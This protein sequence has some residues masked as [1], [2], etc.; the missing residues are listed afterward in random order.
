MSDDLRKRLRSVER[1]N[2][3]LNGRVGTLEFQLKQVTELLHG[4]VR[5]ALRNMT[6]AINQHSVDSVVLQAHLDSVSPGW[7]AAASELRAEVEGKV[8]ALLG[9]VDLSPEE[10]EA[11]A[12]ARDTSEKFLTA[13]S[14]RLGQ[15]LSDRVKREAALTPTAPA[16]AARS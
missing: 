5:T 7:D 16:P 8:A 15:R 12:A 13:A 14:T 6:A 2:I 10:A 3:R 9:G 4:D 1:E 11:A